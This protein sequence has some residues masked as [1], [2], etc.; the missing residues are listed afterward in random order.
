MAEA[1]FLRCYWYYELNLL[2]GGVPYYTDPIKDID[3]AK[4]SRLSMTEVW[5]ELVGDLTDCVNESNL[6]DKYNSSD[7][8]YGHITKGVA[9][10]LKG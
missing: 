8:D 3:E 6:P 1:K 10:A 5:N 4:G 9:Y 2:F 7:P